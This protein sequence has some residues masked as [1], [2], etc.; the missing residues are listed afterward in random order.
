[1]KNKDAQG[2]WFE[3]QEGISQVITKEVKRFKA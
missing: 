1:M 2:N 3:D